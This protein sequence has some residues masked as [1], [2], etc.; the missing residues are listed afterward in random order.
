MTNEEIKADERY[1]TCGRCKWENIPYICNQCKWGEDT[2]KDLWE[3]KE[4]AGGSESNFNLEQYN[5]DIRGMT[6]EEC[7]K[8]WEEFAESHES[9]LDDWIENSPTYQEW[10]KDIEDAR[11]LA[12]W[13]TELKARRE[14]DKL[15]D[16]QFKELLQEVRE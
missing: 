16:A 9:T 6:L 3:L 4:Y 13:L 7:I 2:R 1:H 15:A 14:A 11:Q 5:A 10:K 8:N 12:E